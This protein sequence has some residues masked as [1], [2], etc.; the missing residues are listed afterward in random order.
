MKSSDITVTDQFCGAGGSS[1]GAEQAGAKL[2]LALNHDVVAIKTHN[3]NF[4]HADH[5]CTDISACDPRRYPSTSLLITSPECTNHTLAQGRKRKYQAQLELFGK[6]TINP[7]EERSRATMWDVVRFAEYHKYEVVIVENVVD[8]RYWLLWEPWLKAMEALGYSHKEVYFNSQFAHLSPGRTFVPQSRDR[9]YVVF[10]KRGNKA[11]DLEFRPVAHCPHCGKDVE[12]EQIWKNPQKPWGK[13]RFQ[14]LYHCPHNLKHGVVHP[15]SYGAWHVINWSLPI[16]KIGEKSKPLAEATLRRIEK[17]LKKFW[18]KPLLVQDGVVPLVFNY[19]REGQFTSLAQPLNTIC[20][21]NHKYL[22]S[23]PL[24]Y[25]YQKPHN[26]TNSHFPL[27]TITTKDKQAVVMLPSNSTLDVNECGFRMFDPDEI[28]FGMAFPQ[29]YILH[30]TKKER[31]QQ[32]GNAV[33]P[34]VMELLVSRV[35]ETFQ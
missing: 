27:P 25:G 21:A 6:A 33:T 1:Y 34:P 11:P 35:I 32:L 7:D 26:L 19:Q 20:G 8:V 23:I 30:G 17:G 28:R 9:I 2:K 24:I 10:W 31:V 29:N 4:P 22:M 18:S 16:E 14:Y 13:Y 15:Y 12:A 3:S 5:D